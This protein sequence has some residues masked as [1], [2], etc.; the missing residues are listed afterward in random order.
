MTVGSCLIVG[1]GLA[2]LLAAHR[3]QGA[4]IDVTLLEQAP[5][6]G[7]RMA[8]QRVE[9]PKFAPAV[10]DHG[11]QF[12]TVREQRF[13]SL[14]DKW[15]ADSKVRLWS[16]GFATGDGSYYADGHPRYCGSSGMSAIPQRLAQGSN[17]HLGAV[18]SSVEQYQDGW[19][20]LMANGGSHWAEA[21]ILTPPVPQSLGL[22]DAGTF[23]LPG[24]ARRVLESITYEPCIALML[25]LDGP[26][27]IPEPGGMWPLGEPIAWLADNH[28]KGI[29]PRPGAIT[30]HAGPD[31]SSER[32]N[33]DD[34]IISREL[35]TTAADWLQAAVVF[36]QVHRWRYSKPI[37]T[38]SEPYL[39]I[40]TGAPL[41][42]AGDAFAGPRV[43]GAALSGLAAADW[44]LSWAPPSS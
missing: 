33:T 13:Q 26:G 19:Q 37:R 36:S 28:R 21:L 16:R 4:G 14:V 29:S 39:A 34:Q 27:G 2:G 8:T 44:L 15:R 12:F 7:G 6:V 17:C 43:E 11:A 24:A 38:H 42:F 30:I 23:K 5:G 25:L 10:F 20:A 32:W 40:Q 41:L 31:F 9:F 35:T 3:L 18:V 1:A 22:L